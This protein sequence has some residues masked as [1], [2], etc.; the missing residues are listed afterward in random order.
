MPLF[1]PQPAPSRAPRVHAAWPE[2]P[3]DRM[4]RWPRGARRWSEAFGVGILET[5]VS[6]AGI[7]NFCPGPPGPIT[8]GRVEK[9]VCWKSSPLF[10]F[11]EYVFSQCSRGS[12]ACSGRP[13][14]AS[15]ARPAGLEEG[16]RRSNVRKQKK[17]HSQRPSENDRT[18]SPKSNTDCGR[19][20]KGPLGAEITQPGK[21]QTFCA[22]SGYT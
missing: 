21:Q 5:S 14:D 18:P 13:P 4:G 11:P 20:A 10:L 3:H 19:P 22:A 8:R 12:A 6:S 7:A 17:Q 9:S 2:P 1:F 15:P 16:T